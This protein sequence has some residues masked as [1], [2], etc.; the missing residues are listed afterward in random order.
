MNNN[1]YD[2]LFLIKIVAG[3]IFIPLVLILLE[4]K[5][6]FLV[7]VIS[8]FALLFT[9]IGLIKKYFSIKDIK[10]IQREKAFKE[11]IEKEYKKNNKKG[12]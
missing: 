8:L 7:G 9:E 1:K 3:L 11:M 12:R 2:V 4:S 5:G 6:L 10:I